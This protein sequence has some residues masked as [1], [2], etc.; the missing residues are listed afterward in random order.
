MFR[1]V[2]IFMNYVIVSAHHNQKAKYLLEI[3]NNWTNINNI[4]NSDLDKYHKR[5]WLAKNIN[6]IGMK[7]SSHFLRNIGYTELAI[8]DRHILKNLVK[9][10]F[11]DK[12]PNIL[13][14]IQYLMVEEKFKEFSNTL[15]VPIDELDLLL[16]SNETGEIRK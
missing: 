16:W 10:H 15:D 14:K 11:Y 12:L 3:Q 9:L 7:E 6:G 8:L 5:I 1:K 2:N 13:C 4:L